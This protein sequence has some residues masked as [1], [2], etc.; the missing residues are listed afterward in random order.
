MPARSAGELLLAGD[1]GGTYARLRLYRCDPRGPERMVHEAMFPSQK[2]KSLGAVVGA[3]LD[4]QKAKVDVAVLGIA[5]PVVEGK[6]RA[7][8]LPWKADE[9]SLSRELGIPKVKLVNDLAAVA[10][11]CTRLGRRDRTVLWKGSAVPE[12]NMA[13]IAPGTGLGEALLV[14]DGKKYIPCPTEGGHSDFG[15][16][17]DLEMHLL[18][19]LQDEI[20]GGHVS[21]EQFLSGP[22]LGRMYDFFRAHEDGGHDGEGHESAAVER[23]LRSG[24]RNAAIT[25]LGIARKSRP[26]AAAVHLFASIYGAEAGNVVMRGLALGGIYL[27]GGIATHIVPSKKAVF[28]AAMRNKGRMAKLLSGVPVILVNDPLVG[29]AGAGH[30]AARLAAE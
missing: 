19:H 22:G 8:N 26:A 14:W 18:A 28:L 20:A 25:E 13:V 21:T 11:G 2:A 3:Y 27:C 24:D 29:L 23:R 10:I 4:S 16:N 7:T 6:V 17:S 30:L 9:R 5:G 1:I 12:S 15:P